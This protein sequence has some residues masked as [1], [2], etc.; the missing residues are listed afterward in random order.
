MQ[1]MARQNNGLSDPLAIVGRNGSAG[2]QRQ[3]PGHIERLA[4]TRM[5]DQEKKNTISEKLLKWIMITSVSLL[6][7]A[8]SILGLAHIFGDSL[9]SAGQSSSTQELEIVIG[10]EYLKVPANKVRFYSQRSSGAYSKLELYMHWPSLSGYHEGLLEEFNNAAKGEN[11]I[12][13]SLE[14]RSMSHDMSG[15]V[16]P[17]YSQFFEGR[18]KLL[19][20][21]LVKQAL[22]ASGGYIDED[23]YYAASSP[24]PFAARCVRGAAAATP[25]CI[26]DIHVGKNIMLT[27]RFHQKHL[28]NWIE[29][30][31][32]LSALVQ[33][34]I[35]QP[36]LKLN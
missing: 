5:D 15:R 32:S 27:Y 21:G 4:K 24:Y 14:P 7:I 31:Q 19:N 11:L 22:S 8:L 3:L 28:A 36:T 25:F 9:S 12:F 35:V 29:L 2:F 30:E 34:M 1:T 17:I 6:L 20:N 18:G 16:G 10:D 13:M 26:R 33:S 23:L